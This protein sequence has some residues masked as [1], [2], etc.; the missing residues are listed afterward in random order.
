M[1]R[2]RLAEPHHYAYLVEDI[3]ATV[4]RL[5]DQLGAGQFFLRRG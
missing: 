3:E 5:V 1:F 2:P 4:N